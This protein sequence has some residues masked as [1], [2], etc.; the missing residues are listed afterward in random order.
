MATVSRA[1][2]S[3]RR[4]PFSLVR[5][6]SFAHPILPITGMFSFFC[7]RRWELNLDLDA[8]PDILLTYEELRPRVVNDPVGQCVVVELLQRLFVL[9]ILG[10]SPDCVAQPEGIAVEQRVWTSDGVAASLTSLRYSGVLG[11]AAKPR[12]V[13]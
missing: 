9:H 12:E 8:D 6:R 7:V 3:L 1:D 4:I 5:Q 11:C 2:T 10:A 13:S